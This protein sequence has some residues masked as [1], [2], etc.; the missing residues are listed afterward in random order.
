MR[1]LLAEEEAAL[2]KVLTALLKH[3]HYAVDAVHNGQN[4]LECLKNDVYDAVI[5]DIMMTE[6]DDISVL[7]KIRAAGNTVPVLILT[8]KARID[9]KVEGLDAGADDY[10]TKPYDSRELLARLR[11]IM[12]R[13]SHIIE[14][15]MVFGNLSLNL[16]T[17]EITGPKGVCRLANKEF[18]ILETFMLNPHILIPMNKLMDKIWGVDSDTEQNVA[19]VY[20]SYVRRKL[21]SV[22]A[23]CTIKALRNV[24]YT[25]ETTQA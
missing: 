12:R 20:I 10:M 4:A 23:N 8:E 14:Q 21:K 5:L 1:I 13:R 18:Q 24:G 7:K 6:L 17:Y 2:S 15:E 19:W 11:A 9:D 16:A 25:L 3:N 22:G